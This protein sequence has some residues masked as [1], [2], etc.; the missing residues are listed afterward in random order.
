MKRVARLTAAAT[1]AAA[2][3]S[4]TPSAFAAAGPR[5][6][7]VGHDASTLATSMG[8]GFSRL[9]T[10]IAHTGTLGQ[11]TVA[12]ANLPRDACLV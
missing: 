4:F 7:C 1:A 2:L 5:A 6:N 11:F 8:V 9:V 3:A 10:D 12:E